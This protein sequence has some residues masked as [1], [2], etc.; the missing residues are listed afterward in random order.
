MKPNADNFKTP[1]KGLQDSQIDSIPLLNH[2]QKKLRITNKKS[3]NFRIRL[4]NT[5]KRN[6]LSINMKIKLFFSLR[7][8]K[9]LM[10]SLKPK[11]KTLTACNKK[12]YYFM[13]RSINTN[14]MRLKYH[15]MSRQLASCKKIF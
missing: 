14:N 5:K 11:T 15:K 6:K 2:N 8:Y 12:K 9:D 7:K 1:I 10:D 13:P 3:Y 4:I